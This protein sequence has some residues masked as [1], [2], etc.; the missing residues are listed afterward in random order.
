MSINIKN[1]E[2]AEFYQPYITAVSDNNKGLIGNLDYSHKKALEL[3]PDVSAVKQMDRYAEDKWTIKEIVEHIIDAERVF[4][5]S[6]KNCAPGHYRS[7]G[8]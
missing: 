1:S 5:S 6:V 4:N 2:Y 8:F 3:L 7:T